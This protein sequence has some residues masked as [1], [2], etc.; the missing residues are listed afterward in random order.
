MLQEKLRNMHTQLENYIDSSRK[1]KK[2]IEQQIKS[3]NV[4]IHKTIRSYAFFVLH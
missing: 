3:L 2:D 1:M 4:G